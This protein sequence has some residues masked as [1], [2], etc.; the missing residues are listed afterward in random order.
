M[1]L[2]GL[3]I[4]GIISQFATQNLKVLLH[5]S[6]MHRTFAMQ[7]NLVKMRL[8]VS[9]A[10]NNLKYFPV[11]QNDPKIKTLLFVCLFCFCYN[12]YFK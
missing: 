4:A 9:S 8:Q 3:V 5:I 11:R 6:T 1:L 7:K 10:V 12:I 2:A